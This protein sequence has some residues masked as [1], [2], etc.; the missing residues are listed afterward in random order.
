MSMRLVKI[1]A[2]EGYAERILQT[3]FEAGFDE[4]STHHN[5][6]H[7]PDGTQERRDVVDIGGSTPRCTR[8]IKLLIEADYFDRELI[9][10][11]VRQPRSLGSHDDIIELT[12]PLPEPDTDIFEELWQFSH[13]TYGLVGRLLIAAGLLAYGLIESKILLI[14]SG[15][16]F[17]P[18]M[19][20]MM[21]AGFG[22][23]G[24]QWK[25]VRQGAIAF[26]AA[27][28]LLFAG[29]AVVAAVASPPMRFTD[30]GTPLL[31]LVISVCVGTAAAL[32]EIDDTGRRELIGLAAASQMAIFPVWLAITLVFSRT[33]AAGLEQVPEKAISFAVNIA[34]LYV[35][36]IVVRALSNAH[37]RRRLR[38]H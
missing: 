32:A 23:V 13:I 16:L 10:F 12:K 27:L 28:V 33:G 35:T 30:F 17:L 8:F 5:T 25:L 6:R 3:A 22:T 37:A 19:P 1:V 14:I 2:P 29:G 24:K 21:A 31:G 4:G 15:L 38:S 18:I 36:I 9:K 11:E 26:G 34:A 20:M 7:R